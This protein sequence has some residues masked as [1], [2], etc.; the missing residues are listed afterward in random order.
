MTRPRRARGSS[1]QVRSTATPAEERAAPSR[2]AVTLPS[3]RSTTAYLEY[4]RAG[5]DA[6]QPRDARES[7]PGLPEGRQ[8][9]LALADAGA[10]A[11]APE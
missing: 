5:G 1:S 11:L 4:T 10:V 9:R 8:D 7:V 2:R 6:R 3:R